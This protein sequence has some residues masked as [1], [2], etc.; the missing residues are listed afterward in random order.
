MAFLFHLNFYI[1]F[2]KGEKQSTFTGGGERREWRVGDE[3]MAFE[4]LTVWGGVLL[5]SPLRLEDLNFIL[6]KPSFRK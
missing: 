5:P 4:L 3:E 2:V 6:R 1:S